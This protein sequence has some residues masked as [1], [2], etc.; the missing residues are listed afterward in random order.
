M[1]IFS[2]LI[3]ISP[4]SHPHII[5]FQAYLRNRDINEVKTGVF[6]LKGQTFLVPSALVLWDLLSTRVHSFMLPLGQQHNKGFG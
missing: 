1:G 4:S 3:Y 6:R 2:C 5:P